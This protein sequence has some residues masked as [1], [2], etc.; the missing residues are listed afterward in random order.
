MQNQNRRNFLKLGAL[1]G[2]SLIASSAYS[3][4]SNHQN[5]NSPVFDKITKT[6]FLGSGKN[7]FISLGLDKFCDGVDQVVF[8]QFKKKF[9]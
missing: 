9:F 6:R 8:S 1:T 2:G 4:S 5:N 7:T 3:M